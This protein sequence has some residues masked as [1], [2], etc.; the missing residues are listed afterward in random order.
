MDRKTH[1]N[2]LASDP[3]YRAAF[4]EAEIEAGDALE[5]K[6]TEFGFEGNVTACIFLLKGLKPD[7]FRERSSVDATFKGDITVKRLIG[8][9]EDE[10]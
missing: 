7:K 8:V 1:Y 10:I 5:D 4:A 9:P 6:L 2:W 3:I